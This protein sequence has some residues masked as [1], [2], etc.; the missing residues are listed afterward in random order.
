LLDMIAV[1]LLECARSMV[2]EDDFTA[3]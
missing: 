2:L 3:P 1:S